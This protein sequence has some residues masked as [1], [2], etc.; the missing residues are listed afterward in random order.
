MAPASLVALSAARLSPWYA[1]KANT[2]IIDASCAL[3]TGFCAVCCDNFMIEPSSIG[4]SVDGC[5]N[6][7]YELT[8]STRMKTAHRLLRSEL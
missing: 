7:Q 6:A 3:D 1:A 5:A 8:R 4:S 2:L